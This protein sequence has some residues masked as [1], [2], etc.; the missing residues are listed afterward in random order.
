MAAIPKRKSPAKPGRTLYGTTLIELTPIELWLNPD[1][2]DAWAETHQ[3]ATGATPY[4]NIHPTT[5][6]HADILEEVITHEFVHCLEYYFAPQMR[7]KAPKDC[8]W[9]AI[10]IGRHLPKMLR[11]LTLAPVAT[12]PPT[13]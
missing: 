9:H 11:Y 10:Y 7:R 3:E 13:P 12:K 4:I 1:L 5:L 8:S 2:E 6:E